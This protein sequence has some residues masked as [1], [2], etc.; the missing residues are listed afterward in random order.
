MEINEDDQ[1][2]EL[3][4]WIDKNRWGQG[5][6]T[7]AAAEALRF[8]FEE[9]SLHKIFAHYMTIN[10]A[11]GRVMDK[12]GMKQEGVLPGHVRKWGEFYDIVVYGLLKS[13]YE[14]MKTSD[15]KPTFQ[16]N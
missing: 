15:Q 3:G 13:E 2:A 8:G 11:S 16:A 9:L 4:Y 5:F 12:I 10:P 7:E 14:K 1:N 6:C